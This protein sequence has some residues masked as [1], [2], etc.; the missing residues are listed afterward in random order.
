MANCATLYWGNL[1]WYT[2]I[3]HEISS[4]AMFKGEPWHFRLYMGV[5]GGSV[6]EAK[7]QVSTAKIQDIIV[8]ACVL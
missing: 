8:C 3:S 4:D 1:I 7:K 6:L 5:E 2:E